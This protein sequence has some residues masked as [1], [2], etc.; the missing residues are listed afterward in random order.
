M[1]DEFINSFINE[2]RELLFQLES[3]LLL[4]EKSPGDRQITDNIFRVMH[5]LKGAA[6]MYGFDEL[7][8]LA[9][10]FENIFDHIRSGKLKVSKTLIDD[11]LRGKDIL[12]SML[13]REVQSEENQSFLNQFFDRYEESK[14]REIKSIVETVSDNKRE[15][16]IFCIVFSP[17]KEVFERGLNPDQ[18]IKELTGSGIA[19][20]RIHEKNTAWA[21]QLEQRICQTAWE[22]YLKTSLSLSEIEEVFLFYDE[23]EYK[24]F[25]LENPCSDLHPDL[26]DFLSKHYTGDLSYLKHVQSFIYQLIPDP[27]V[28]DI[29]NMPDQADGPFEEVRP[30][31]IPR[32][33]K[34]TGIK[35][36]SQ[37]LDELMNLVSE[38]VITSATLEAR[39]TTFHDVQLNN[40][41]ENL[42]KLTKKFRTNALDLRLIPIGNLLKKFKRQV[43]DLSEALGKKVDLI[44][45]GQETEIDKSILMSIES[46]L[47]HILRN[48]IDHGIEAPGERLEK[49]KKAEGRIKI[50]AF[51][52]GANVVIQVHDDGRG[53]D[54]EKISRRA[55][56]Q[57][58]FAIDQQVNDR[59][60]LNLIMEP[61]F[62]TSENVSMVSGRGVGMDVVKRELN[63]IGGS[64]EIETEKNLG[65]SITL[66]LPTTLSIIDTLMLEVDESHILV[67]LLEV[68]YCYKESRNNIYGKN[69]SYVQ[70]KNNMIPFISLRQKFKFPHHDNLDEM[71]IIISK[72]DKKYAIIVD[73]I[74]GEHQAVIKSLGELFANQPY[75]SGGSIM[76]DGNLALVL[77]TNYLFNQTVLN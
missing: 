36:S 14:A 29:M 4:M 56:D 7:Q 57:G 39:S 38:L 30:S 60:L 49:G 67:P 26:R 46:P 70:Y 20:V 2:A 55:A 34:E 24:V 11:T 18:V 19:S 48:S 40:C 61:G 13:D 43:R 3:D 73:D 5:N 59:E 45:E 41:I 8:L 68:E 62:T 58:Y 17:D 9:H 12:L 33:H 54:L 69:S 10:A 47:M 23:G 63:A 1:T 71:V 76:A 50:S 31:F 75:Y 66:K 51:Y 6:R 35:V 64:I 25:R 37:K 22:I 42:E 65:T 74:L 28:N 72:Y 44:L 32:S 52:S 15:Q 53:I 16:E 27:S 21:V 77:D